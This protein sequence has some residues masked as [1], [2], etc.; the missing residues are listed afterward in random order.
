MWLLSRETR[1][2]ESLL[3]KRSTCLYDTLHNATVC[4]SR[5]PLSSV[6]GKSLEQFFC[7]LNLDLLSRVLGLAGRRIS[8]RDSAIFLR[9]VKVLNDSVSVLLENLLWNT[10]HA[11]N[12][13]L[14]SLP[15]GKCIL[16]LAERLL[17]HLV[18][19]DG[20]TCVWQWLASVFFQLFSSRKIN[21]APFE[22]LRVQRRTSRGVQSPATSVAFEMFGL[23][24][25]D[26]ELQI[27]E[28]TL[29]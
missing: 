12:L 27:F 25:R 6:L 13:D 10:L 17:V 16:D 14:E 18:Q 24:V 9:L 22:N 20:K 8:S 28:I 15:V 23:L 29:A 7:R 5:F 2:V 11:K 26:Q 19:M 3:R 1:L 21:A 4:C